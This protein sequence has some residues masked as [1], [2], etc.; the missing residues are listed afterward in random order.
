MRCSRKPRTAGIPIILVDRRADV[1]KD[2]YVSYLGSDFVEEGRNAARQ[3]V[4]ITGGKAN[5]VE[6]VGTIDSAPANDRYK[7]FRE[8]LKDYPDM[9]IIDSKSGDFTLAQGKEVMA[10]FLKIVWQNDHGSV[11]AQRRYGRG[12]NP[13]HR[14]G[15]TKTRC[16]Y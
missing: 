1:S 7:G 13:G 6:L 16:G 11:C 2:L 12:R 14:R 3:M 15:R 9:H 5:I 8:I 10:G 4:K